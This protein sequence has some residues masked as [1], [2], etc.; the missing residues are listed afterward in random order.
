[1]LFCIKHLSADGAYATGRAQIVAPQAQAPQ[2]R[3]A[4]GAAAALSNFGSQQGASVAIGVQSDWSGSTSAG[5]LEDNNPWPL[6][7]DSYRPKSPTGPIGPPQR[8]RSPVS[9]KPSLGIP[10]YNILSSV[11]E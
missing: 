1:M 3:V 4:R 10:I 9:A 7:A 5:G 2:N 6:A 11:S 8:A